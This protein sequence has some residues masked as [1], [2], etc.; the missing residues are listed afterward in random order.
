M[1]SGEGP[2]GRDGRVMH[3]LDGGNTWERIAN[4]GLPDAYPRVAVPLFAESMAWLAAD[5]GRIFRSQNPRG[6]WSPAFD[7]GVRINAL[8]AEGASCSVTI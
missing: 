6:G 8:A 4:A 5:D 2:P 1:T 7:L 3:S